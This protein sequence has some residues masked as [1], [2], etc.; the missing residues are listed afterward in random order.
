MASQEHDILNETALLGNETVVVDLSRLG[1]IR[2]QGEDTQTFLQGQLTNDIRQLK[3]DTAQLSAYCTP[4]GRMLANFLLWQTDDGVHA[5][6]PTEL[7]EPI[8]KR[9]S[10][11]IMR[12]KVKAEDMSTSLTPFAI[13]GP[14]AADSIQSILGACPA[15][16]YQSVHAEQASVIRLPQ[17]FFLIVCASAAAEALRSQFTARHPAVGGH[18]LDWWLI[19]SG[20]PLITPSTQE[21]FVPQ[22]ANYE[23][24]GGV[25]FK[26]GCYPGQEIVART[27]YLGKLKR[28]MYRISL[29]AESQATIGDELYGVDM[30][31]QAIGM[32][33][34]LHPSLNGKTEALA[35]LQISSVEAGPIH[36]KAT[37]GAVA[38]ILPLPYNVA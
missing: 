29:P 23:V 31:D 9:L 32:L 8:R 2:F 33:V 11:F 30:G 14:Q 28:R 26:K 37:D 25:N 20:V 7:A 12:S 24:L 19:Q 35:V 21:Q 17:D 3:N 38:D 27:Q 15:Q 5:L 22:M 6:L 4:K 34:N 10:M 18:A 16:E 13:Y 36:H 1:I